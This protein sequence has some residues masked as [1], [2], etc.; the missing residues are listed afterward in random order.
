MYS[1]IIQLEESLKLQAVLT[2]RRELAVWP[3]VVLISLS[4]ILG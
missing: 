4:A 2:K 3:V 1:K